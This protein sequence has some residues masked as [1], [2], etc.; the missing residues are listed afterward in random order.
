MMKNY[1]AI[2]SHDWQ[3][4]LIFWPI[5]Q[6]L[7]LT[8]SPILSYPC[9]HI[10]S[11]IL[12]LFHIAHQRLCPCWAIEPCGIDIVRVW[13][14]LM[15]KLYIWFDEFAP[16]WVAE[17]AERDR[18]GGAEVQSD[19]QEGPATT[20]EPQQLV[21]AGELKYPRTQRNR[22]RRIRYL[23]SQ[24]GTPRPTQTLRSSN[25]SEEYSSTRLAKKSKPHSPTESPWSTTKLNRPMPSSRRTRQ[26]KKPWL[27]KYRRPRATTTKWHKNYRV[28]DQE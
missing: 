8:C 24:V 25:R 9:P 6:N 19:G 21:R 20:P 22:P 16:F 26:N 18:G 17:A 5:T 4:Y 1:V 2:L 15:L 28:N 11:F 12:R 10:S 23:T 7:T 14:G 13:A 27:K 3:Y